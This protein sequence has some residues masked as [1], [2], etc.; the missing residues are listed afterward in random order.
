[1]S[2]KI[3]NGTS[4]NKNGWKYISIKGKPRER[5]YAYG[6]LCAE[7]FK[8]IQKTLKFLMF[9]V[10]VL[11][12]G[13][14]GCATW[15]STS[16][17]I[18]D[19]EVWHQR[20]VRKILKIK[21]FD[22]ISFFDIVHLAS[23]CGYRLVPIELRIRECRLRYLG[24]VERMENSRLPKILLHAE[25]DLGKRDVGQPALNYRSCIKKGRSGHYFTGDRRFR[26]FDF[27]R[28]KR[29]NFYVP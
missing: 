16:E 9:E 4:Y 1:M 6:Y 15:N 10:L 3:K 19:L 5:G 24:H 26:L 2:T 28:R 25:C 20:A 18:H 12:A 17:N 29:T 14:Y 23:K 13:L 27:T 22:H 21:W 11:S 7:D 8:D